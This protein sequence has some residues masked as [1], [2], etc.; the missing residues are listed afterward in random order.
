[1]EIGGPNSN[2]KRKESIE[3]LRPLS[4]I[5]INRVIESNGT[6]LS[7]LSYRCVNLVVLKFP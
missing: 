3:I 1:M 4:I 2:I 7:E 5:E 6:K